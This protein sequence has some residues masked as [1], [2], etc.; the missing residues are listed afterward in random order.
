[1]TKWEYAY[2]IIKTHDKNL[3]KTI[4]QWGDAGWEIIA[5]N[6]MYLSEYT[7]FYFKR[8]KP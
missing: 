5:A 2:L 6:E 4:N 8:P 3:E 7:T 1:M